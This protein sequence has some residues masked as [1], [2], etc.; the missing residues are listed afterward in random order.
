MAL[1]HHTPDMIEFRND[2]KAV[3]GDDP[4]TVLCELGTWKLESGNG[5][6][7]L[8]EVFGPRGPLLSASETRKLGKWLLKAADEL[9]GESHKSSE[10]KGQKK[11]RLDEEDE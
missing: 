9:E 2:V 1:V 8:I 10:R 7:V 4:P 5:S 3:E 6:G 11:R